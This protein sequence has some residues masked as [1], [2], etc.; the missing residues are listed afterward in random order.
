MSSAI[1]FSLDQSRILSSGNRLMCPPN[2]R[3]LSGTFT[4][5]AKSQK[6]LASCDCELEVDY[7]INSLRNDEILDQSKFK[8]LADNKINATEK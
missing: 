7:E 3:D 6:V 5:S 2:I 4:L 8:E 1:C